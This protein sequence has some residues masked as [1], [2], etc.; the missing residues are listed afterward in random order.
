MEENNDK[1]TIRMEIPSGKVLEG[2]AYLISA[3]EMWK[4]AVDKLK[5]DENFF[6]DMREGN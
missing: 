5:E 4:V 3:K 6:I 2:N 1:R